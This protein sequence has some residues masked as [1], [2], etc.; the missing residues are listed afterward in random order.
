M[1]I[2]E[3]ITNGQVAKDSATIAN[4]SKKDSSSMKAIAVLTM[5]FLPGTFLA[6]S[7]SNLIIVWR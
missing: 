6:V 1:A 7:N 2:K 5:F 3:A 4:E